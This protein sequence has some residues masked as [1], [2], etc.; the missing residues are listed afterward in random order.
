MSLH[1]RSAHPDETAAIGR[2]IAALLVPGDVV[3]LSGPLG[4]GV[5]KHVCCVDQSCLSRG[6]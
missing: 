1:L 6:V 3:V 2:S 5:V 4:A